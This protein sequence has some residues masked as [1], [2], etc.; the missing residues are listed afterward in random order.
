MPARAKPINLLPTTDFE[1][2]FWG[3]FLK[4]A[5]TSGR[6]IIIV[7]EILVILAFLSRFKLDQDLDTIKETIKNQQGLLVRQKPI[8]DEFRLVQ[9]RLDAT[10]M[11]IKRQLDIREKTEKVIATMPPEIKLE[12]LAIMTDGITVQA[13]TLSEQAIGQML[14]RMAQEPMF[15]ELEMTNFTTTDGS[16]IKFTVQLKT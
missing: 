1:L 14:T 12:S 11:M 3:K 9:A 5:V 7:T 8:E 4:W 10:D 13:I 2:S 6:Y 15:K 16:A